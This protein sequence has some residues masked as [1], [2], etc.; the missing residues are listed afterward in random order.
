MDRLPI[1]VGVGVR[2]PIHG[3]ISKQPFRTAVGAGVDPSV[4]DQSIGP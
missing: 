1:L 3:R 4:A 2:P